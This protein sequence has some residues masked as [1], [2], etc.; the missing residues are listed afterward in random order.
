MILS[1]ITF[2]LELWEYVVPDP[3]SL[4]V[5]GGNA[6]TT[7]QS[8]RKRKWNKKRRRRGR[9]KGNRTVG[10]KSGSRFCLFKT[11]VGGG[12]E[13]FWLP[14]TIKLHKKRIIIIIS[15]TMI[16]FSIKNKSLFYKDCVEHGI[17]LVNQLINDQGLLIYVKISATIYT[18]GICSDFWCSTTGCATAS[19]IHRKECCRKSELWDFCWRSIYYQKVLL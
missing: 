1:V 9:R 6:P 8:R 5:G 15:G 16:I 11:P 10:D 4:P 7:N 12:N 13:A 14:T 2:N 17:L 18:E 19:Q 3:Y